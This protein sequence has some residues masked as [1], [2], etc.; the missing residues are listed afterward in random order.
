MCTASCMCVWKAPSA[1]VQIIPRLQY[2][3]PV[4]PMWTVI[5]PTVGHCTQ[6]VAG[7]T[8]QWA[9]RGQY[10]GTP[11]QTRVRIEGEHS[12]DKSHEHAI[13]G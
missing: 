1:T 4:A 3:S 8:Q 13:N 7:K 12:Y 5:V 11:P 10:A 9:V 6:A 2:R